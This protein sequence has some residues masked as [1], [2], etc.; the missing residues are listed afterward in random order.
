MLTSRNGSRKMSFI[1]GLLDLS[2]VNPIMNHLFKSGN[3]FSLKLVVKKA[4]HKGPGVTGR[5]FVVDL[6]PG[7]VEKCMVCLV[8]H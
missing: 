3:V 2:A 4:G 5:C 7:V 6:G 1:K 8:L